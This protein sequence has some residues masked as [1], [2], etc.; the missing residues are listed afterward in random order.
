MQFHFTDYSAFYFQSIKKIRVP[1]QRGGKFV[2]IVNAINQKEH[3]VLA[4]REYMTYHANIV[5]RFCASNRIA[6]SYNVKRDFFRINDPEWAIAGGGIFEMDDEM[7][8]LKLYGE[9]AA[10]GPFDPSGLEE[11]IRASGQLTDYNIIV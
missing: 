9:S 11:R 10:Y 2:Q 5:E 3:L 1:Q 4:P 8:S 6:G 7:K